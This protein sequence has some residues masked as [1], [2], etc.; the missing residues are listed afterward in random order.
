M[1]RKFILIVTVVVVIFLV[2]G[3]WVK[4]NASNNVNTVKEKINIIEDSSNSRIEVDH[5]YVSN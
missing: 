2:V 3:F 1:S 5:E 4:V